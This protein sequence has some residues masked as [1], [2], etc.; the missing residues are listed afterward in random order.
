M[1]LFYFVL[2]FL[3]QNKKRKRGNND[4]ALEKSPPLEFRVISLV[5]LVGR[6]PFFISHPG[7]QATRR[8]G[9]QADRARSGGASSIQRGRDAVPSNAG[10]AAAHHFLFELLFRGVAACLQR[11]AA[12]KGTRVRSETRR[13]TKSKVASAATAAA[14]ASPRRFSRPL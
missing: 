7:K 14:S 2:T 4:L 6:R 10:A 11:D 12:S 3:K 1:T 5:V 13:R 9:R 8:T